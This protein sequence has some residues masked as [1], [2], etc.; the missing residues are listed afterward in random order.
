MLPNCPRGSHRQREAKFRID[1]EASSQHH[2][3]KGQTSQYE[4]HT[5]PVLPSFL[6]ASAGRRETVPQ[7]STQREVSLIP[8]YTGTLK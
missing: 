6:R 8:Y 5:G 1:L 2:G 4:I 3:D 7:E